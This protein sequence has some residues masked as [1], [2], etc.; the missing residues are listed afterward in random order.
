MSLPGLEALPEFKLTNLAIALIAFVL[1][2][3]ALSIALVLFRKFAKKI[4]EKTKITLDD[5]IYERTSTP[6][7]LIVFYLSFIIAVIAG[8][9]ELR[10]YTYSLWDLVSIIGILLG[11]FLI[12]RIVLS[13]LDWYR[14]TKVLAGEIK[15][16]EEFF[17]ILR[18]LSWLVVYS[19][20]AIIALDR[21][22]I[23]IAPLIAGLGI[24]G[25]AVALALQ[26]SLS[27][28][29]AGVYI[30]ADR[31]IR[32]GDYIELEDGK[33]GFV[34]EIGWRS[35][36]IRML[37]NNIIIIPNSKLAQS[38]ITN[39]S[40]PKNEMGLVLPVDV[41]YGSDP[42]KVERVLKQAAKNVLKRTPGAV[43]DFEPFVRF[44]EFG[45]FALKF[46]VI[47]RVKTYVDKFL[48]T[49]EFNKEVVKQ[50]KKHKIE[51]PFP[52]RTVYLK[53]AK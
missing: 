47:L 40:L 29:F 49:H 6:L 38:V 39:Y 26:E 52:T 3:A 11:A 43:K 16:Y 18:R 19:I 41:A 32:V 51:I 20:A 5:I 2:Y 8:G 14:E 21:L 30:A 9:I 44:L 46:K 25:L 42:E 15:F 36:R 13:L 12:N 34:E 1:A 45:E 27:N 53:R 10:L 31:P 37:A 50:F 17:P 48:V 22:G 33:A 28:L 35:T 23:E 24:A 4:T 7:K